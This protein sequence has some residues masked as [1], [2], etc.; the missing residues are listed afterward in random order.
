MR[1]ATN[2]RGVHK[3]HD[4]PKASDYDSE[5]AP[6][7]CRKARVPNRFGHPR[8]SRCN[9]QCNK[10]DQEPRK[11]THPSRGVRLLFQ[12]VLRGLKSEVTGDGGAGEAPPSGVR[13]DRRVRPHVA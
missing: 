7:E 8:D 4:H 13:V 9:G 10:T 3:W 6:G 2:D 11:R 1:C 5:I 12:L